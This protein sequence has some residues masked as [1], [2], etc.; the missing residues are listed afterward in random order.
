MI[1]SLH[2]VFLIMNVFWVRTLYGMCLDCV[3]HPVTK[4]TNAPP[5]QAFLGST[6][7]LR[8]FQH[9]VVNFSEA[10]S[11]MKRLLSTLGSCRSAE[12]NII[13]RWKTRRFC[14]LSFS[15]T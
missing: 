10:Y 5:L 7:V 1:T 14:S 11:L 15:Y 9:W 6:P 13:G 3:Y 4:A 12:K 8:Q 2:F